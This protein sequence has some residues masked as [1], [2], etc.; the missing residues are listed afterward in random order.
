MAK[1]IGFNPHLIE[2]ANIREQCAFV[3]EDHPESATEKAMVLIRMAVERARRIQPIRKE[4][5]KVEEKGLVV[6]GGLSGMT[7]SLRLAEQGYE[8]YLI[9]REKELGGNLRESFYTLK[10]SNPQT[11]LQDLIK[12]VDRNPSI[13]FYSEAEIIEFE[14]KNGHYRTTI[15]HQNEEKGIDHGALIL[16]TGGK[17]V[18]PKGYLYGEDPR[19]ITQRQL[20]KMIHLK[21]E[22]LK[23]LRSVV[24]IQCV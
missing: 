4:K 5:R 24:M 10:G 3:H 14:K 18:A 8:V 9:E 20:E 7:A 2:Y 21:D 15:R 23:D 17:E 19:V 1:G 11:L 13:H 6:G 12:Q 16:A 22:K